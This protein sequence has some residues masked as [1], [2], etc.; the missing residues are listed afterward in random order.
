MLVGDFTDKASVDWHETEFAL[1]DVRW[2]K[3]DPTAA[4]EASPSNWVVNPDLSKVDEIG[5]TDLRAGTGHG[6]GAFTRFDWIE[7][8]ANKVPR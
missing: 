6:T 3:L 4:V 5:F 2:L 1:T 8:Y 7:V